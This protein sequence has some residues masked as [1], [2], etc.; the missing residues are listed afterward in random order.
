MKNHS[1]IGVLHVWYLLTPLNLGHWYVPRYCN[2]R[3]Q[4]AKIH[5]VCLH[6]L[7]N[8]R[9]CTHANTCLHSV[10]PNCMGLISDNVGFHHVAQRHGTKMSSWSICKHIS[11]KNWKTRGGTQKWAKDVGRGCTPRTTKAIACVYLPSANILCNQGAQSLSEDGNHHV[12]VIDSLHLKALSCALF[13]HGWHIS[14]PLLPTQ[15]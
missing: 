14:I 9:A 3:P 5:P 8:K 1:G 10:T 2:R 12:Q 4:N 15:A 13:M 7:V 11:K 6:A